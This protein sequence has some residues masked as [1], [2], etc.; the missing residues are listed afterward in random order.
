MTTHP[1][2]EEDLARRISEGDEEAFGQVYQMY[3]DRLIRFCGNY[4]TSRQDA[5]DLA[6]D[7]F[8]Q[9]R[10]KIDHFR[11]G[12]K[13]GPWLYKIARNKCLDFLKKKRP[14]LLG[15]QWSDSFSGHTVEL[16]LE[17]VG[18]S[19]ATSAERA[20]LCRSLSEVLDGL[21][22]EQ[23]TVFLLKYVEELTRREIAEILDIPP[24]TVKSRLYNTVKQIRAKLSQE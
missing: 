23:R 5:E 17:A 18:P 15:K 1:Q 19:P 22:E 24:A 3:H 11:I 4:V 10:R 13:I 2:S 7:A 21:K 20:D 6:Q 8:L 16:N 9:F 12:E 14:V